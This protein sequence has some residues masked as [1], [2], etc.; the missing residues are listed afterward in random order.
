MGIPQADGLDDAAQIDIAAG[1]PRPAVMGQRGDHRSRE[2]QS[3]DR[4]EQEPHH[5]A[6]PM[7][8]ALPGRL[9]HTTGHSS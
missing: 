5:R 6:P 1:R 4:D 9:R 3:Q 8:Q 2:S 7:P